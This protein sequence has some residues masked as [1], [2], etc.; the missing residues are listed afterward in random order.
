MVAKRNIKFHPE[1]MRQRLTLIKQRIDR[2][3]SEAS[4]PYNENNNSKN[5]KGCNRE[6]QQQLKQMATT[7]RAKRPSAATE[8]Q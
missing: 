2:S 3:T 1:T 5:C 4:Y 8:Q 6:Q 7:S